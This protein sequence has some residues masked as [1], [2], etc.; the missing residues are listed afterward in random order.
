MS[1]EEFRHIVRVMNTNIPGE[2][3]VRYGLQDIKGIG[4]RTAKVLIETLGIDGV[5]SIGYLSSEDV[6]KLNAAIEKLDDLLPNWMVN[7]RK[8]PRTGLDTHLIGVDLDFGIKED[9]ESMKR[10]RCYRGIRHERRL[11]VRGQ[12]T[13]SNGRKGL[14]IGVQRRAI[15]ERVNK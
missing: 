6:D 4:D 8:E 12:R 11:K 9:L 10:I 2:K 5:K 1:E 7:H 13:R 15:R 14:A 3:K